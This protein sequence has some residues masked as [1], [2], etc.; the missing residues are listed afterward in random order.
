MHRAA[1]HLCR[2][3]RLAPGGRVWVQLSD[4]RVRV[5]A[6]TRGTP[7]AAGSA[8]A[9][10]RA[11]APPHAQSA[12]RCR[13]QPRTRPPRGPAP[14]PPAPPARPPPSRACFG[15]KMCQHHT[16]A[17]AVPPACSEASHACLGTCPL[18]CPGPNSCLSACAACM[19]API[20]FQARQRAWR[21][22]HDAY[23]TMTHSHGD[24]T[25][26]HRRDVAEDCCARLF[27]LSSCAS[28]ARDALR[29]S[30]LRTALAARLFPAAA[31]GKRRVTGAVQVPQAAPRLAASASSA[32][33]PSFSR[34]ARTARC[35]CAPACSLHVVTF[36]S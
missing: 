27:R 19:T 4:Q 12:R 21:R 23:S 13:P 36:G 10:S 15:F 2:T 7:R 26:R 17:L 31:A 1:T 5:R 29:H 34:S 8:A 9:A 25:R 6:P 30:R 11:A 33:A 18:C 22:Q 3:D 20:L 16:I 35:C 28:M 14:P 24:G 32:A